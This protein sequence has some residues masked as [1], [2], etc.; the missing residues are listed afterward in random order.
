M[1]IVRRR[2]CLKWLPSWEEDQ[3]RT[4]IK[5]VNQARRILSTV[6]VTYNYKIK[7]HYKKLRKLPSLRFKAKFLVRD[8]RWIR[9]ER[10]YLKAV[11][12]PA[13]LDYL[14]NK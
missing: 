13:L 1:N 8:L 3:N 2:K 5:K 11:E 12:V 10:V 7:K 9:R 14:K 6:K 4:L